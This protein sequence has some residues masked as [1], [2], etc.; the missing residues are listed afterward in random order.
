[1]E[2]ELIIKFIEEEKDISLNIMQP[3]L[4]KLIHSIVVDELYVTKDN[5]KITTD[6]PDFDTEEFR[7]IFLS[8]H[9]E[10]VE[11][12]ETFYKNIQNDISTYYSNSDLSETII[13]KIKDQDKSII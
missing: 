1:M 5:I 7:D 6:S 10:F 3:D 8:V 9:E 13:N 12:I 4:A 2:N 11:E